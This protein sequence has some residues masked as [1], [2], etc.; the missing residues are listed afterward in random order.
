MKFDFL[1]QVYEQ[2]SWFS[3]GFG[4]EISQLAIL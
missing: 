2:K 1:Q 3:S 4:K